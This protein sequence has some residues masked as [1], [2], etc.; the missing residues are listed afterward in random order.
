MTKEEFEAWV[1][2]S[3]WH[4][5]MDQICWD[6]NREILLYTGGPHGK[7]IWVHRNGQ[8]DTGTYRGAMPDILEAT[9]RKTFS[10]KFPTQEDAY[11]RVVECGGP[12][13]LTT[14]IL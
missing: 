3:K 12:S 7:F 8:L 1:K 9:F 6:K 13:Y 10:K 14:V 5:I 11:R 4:W 2:T